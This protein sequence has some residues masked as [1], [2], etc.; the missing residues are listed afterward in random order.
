MRYIDSDM[1][2]LSIQEACLALAIDQATLYRWLAQAGITPQADAYDK[3]RRVLTQEQV[4]TLA[5]IH[6][7]PLS[8]DLAAGVTQSETDIRLAAQ[9][10]E[11]ED[12]KRRVDELEIFVAEIIEAL[13]VPPQEPQMPMPPPERAATPGTSTEPLHLDDINSAAVQHPMRPPASRPASSRA[14]PSGAGHTLPEGYTPLH[15]FLHGVPMNTAERSVQAFV[16][17]G[18]WIHEG[19]VV[20]LALDAPG[21]ARAYEVLLNHPSFQPCPACPHTE[22]L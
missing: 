19:Y 5:Q 20:K 2:T 17:R 7:R 11:I 15:E 6:R 22:P 16:K 18:E 12:L 8:R 14:E 21:R 3:R 9:Q 13:S 10:K 1:K 4:S